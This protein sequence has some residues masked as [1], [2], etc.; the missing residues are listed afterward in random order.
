MRILFALLALPLFV[1]T[2]Q[3]ET[4]TTSTST[5]SMPT[6]M[7]MDQRFQQANVTHDGHLTED[8]AKTGYKSIAR[9]F[10]A[11][12]QDKK[13]YI[14]EDDIRTYDKLQRILHQQQSSST[15]HATNN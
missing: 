14:T 5:K 3:A 10:S 2:A 13:G 9:H 15:K 6:H 4:T 8:Q 12:D 11:I 7:T 1:L